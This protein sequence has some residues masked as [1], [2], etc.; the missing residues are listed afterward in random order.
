MPDPSRHGEAP[1]P[2]VGVLDLP[3]GRFAVRDEHSQI[4]TATLD[5]WLT[6]SHAIML[7]EHYPEEPPSVIAQ[8]PALRVMIIDEEPA[9]RRL[10]EGML[11]GLDVMVARDL[12]Q[13]A[14]V[15][16]LDPTRVAILDLRMPGMEGVEAVE[17]LRRR[18]PTSPIVVLT[19]SVDEQVGL[20]A[21]SVGAQDFLRK[22]TVD[23]E[24]LLRAIRYAKQ[25]ADR[26][27]DLERRVLDD[28]LTGLPNR[29]LIRDRIQHA[30]TK[31]D[32]DP[33]AGVVVLFIDLDGF[34]EINDRFGHDAGDRVLVTLAQRLR[35][36]VRT[37]DSIGRYGGDEFVAVC[38]GIRN[39]PQLVALI[40][41]LSSAILQGIRF[42]G[43][44]FAVRASIGATFG[45][46]GSTVDEMLTA[47]DSAMYVAKGCR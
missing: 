16:A 26:E 8:D 4:D 6:A 2:S 14:E 5:G 21:I 36:A 46:P 15:L 1:S 30:L 37:A 31:L 9:D 20:Q 23:R 32:R 47:A 42:E 44:S 27:R 13:A 45:H 41:R 10:V 17:H 18:A 38:E 29:R 22:D 39:G 33:S 7:G 28:P 12:D 40:E 34:K 11:E 35:K 24:M 25:R 19:A 3:G 43:R